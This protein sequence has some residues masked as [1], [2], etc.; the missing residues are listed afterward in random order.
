[1]HAARDS[2]SQTK[3]GREKITPQVR[4]NSDRAS[5]AG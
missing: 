5:S 4:A 2:I 3:K 1:L